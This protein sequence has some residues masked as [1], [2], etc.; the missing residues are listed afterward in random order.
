MKKEYSVYVVV[1]CTG[2]VYNIT[3]SFD[4]AMCD[5]DYLIKIG[6]TEVE[7]LTDMTEII[8]ALAE[9]VND[10]Q[11]VINFLE[12]LQNNIDKI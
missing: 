9:E 10:K 2:F 7:I 3:D 11:T 5:K 6:S 4:E 1:D 12:F 8:D